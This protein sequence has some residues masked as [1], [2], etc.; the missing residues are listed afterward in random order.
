MDGFFDLLLLPP[1]LRGFMAIVLAGTAF[2][3]TGVMVVRM[4][5]L[6][7]R[8]TLM[9]GLILGGAISL[10]LSL[11]PLPVYIL[12]GFAVVALMLL[13][14]RDRRVGLGLSSA[15]LM[16]LSVAAAAIIADKA[17]VPSKD[18]L[19]MLWG[20]PFTVS[21]TELM[22][23]AF[24]SLMIILYL[25][26]A[27]RKLA[28]IFFDRDTALTIDRNIR[29]HEGIAVMLTALTV[30]LSMRF[31]GALL[32]DALLLL[33]VLIAMKR[34]SGL[35]NLFILSSLSGL[36]IAGGGYILALILDL[37]PSAASA[38][39]AG[40]LYIAVPRRKNI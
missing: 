4:N 31:V 1:I 39:L 2:P 14:G 17:D 27:F 10:A 38:T 40:V 12:S 28:L 36:V 15:V 6:P 32:I 22:V 7:L 21:G 29:I 30:S 23:F 11:P 13:I 37:T 18:T 26:I 34:A 16:V 33:P 9:H 19:S 20:S 3:V 25:V 5:L 24:L 35:K 8:Y